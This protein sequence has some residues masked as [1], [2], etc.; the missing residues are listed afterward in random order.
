MVGRALSSVPYFLLV[1]RTPSALSN[2]HRHSVGSEARTRAMVAV[3]ASSRVSK[4]TNAPHRTLGSRRTLSVSSTITPRV[5]SLP[6]KSCVSSYPVALLRTRRLVRTSLPSGVTTR[7]DTTFSAVVPYMRVDSPDPRVLAIP[8]TEGFDAGSGPKS[9]P[10]SASSSFSSDFF[11]P[12]P[13]WHCISAS[14]KVKVFIRIKS[15]TI[16]PW[17]GIAPPS[18]PLPAPRGT[19]GT[20]A[21]YAALTT[22]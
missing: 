6:T 14:W 7:S 3:A 13:T 2:S 11:N 19:M 21:S 15:S 9:M 18:R 22:A 20:L 17:Y 12:G 5:P 8:P 16:P 10:C 1:A 4:P